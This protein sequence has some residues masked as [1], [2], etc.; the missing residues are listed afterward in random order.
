MRILLDE[1]VP[2]QVCDALP[3]HD[4]TTAQKMGW[5]GKSNGDLL[6]SA[7]QAGFGVFIV[8]DKNL[9]YQQNLSGRRIT[10]LELW[11]NH[12]PTL[13]KHFAEI[14]VAVEKLTAGEYSIL[15]IP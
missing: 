5:G 9:R 6:N 10:I 1:C 15:E 2:I 12:R 13:E 7:E 8:A 3:G 4:V 14:R 11:T